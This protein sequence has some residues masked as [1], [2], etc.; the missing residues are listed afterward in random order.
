MIRRLRL[1]FI[2]IA[3]GSLLALFAVVLI[4]L[5]LYMFITSLQQ[6]GRTLQAVAA[7]DGIQRDG[8]GHGGDQSEALSE[9]D[10]MLIRHE[11]YFYLK[12]N[13]DGTIREVRMDK[14]TNY[15]EKDAKEHLEQVLDVG[16]TSGRLEGLQ[17]LAVEKEYG[18]LFVFVERGSDL[19]MLYRLLRVS[20]LS[21]GIG[22]ALLLLIVFFLSRWAVRPV[23]TAFEKQQQFVSDASH[24][25]KTPLTILSSNI[26]M[27]REEQPEN[28]ELASVQRQASRMNKLIHDLLIL[29][30]TEELD[31]LTDWDK[32]DFSKAVV[33]TV[34]EFESLALEE[35][36][37][38]LV[39]IVD[40]I[41][42]EGDKAQLKQVATILIDNAVKHSPAGGEIRV[43]LEE[44]HGK[45]RLAV[46]NTGEGI[47]AAERER[48]FERFYRVD[49]SR[50]RDTGGYGLGLSIAKAIVE[51]HGGSIQVE[52][53]DHGWVEFV[54]LFPVSK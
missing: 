51:R 11:N 27:L 1:K 42:Y 40:D 16:K 7:A 3:M 9:A 18:Y 54:V 24:E 47:P 4:S 35:N 30:R 17:Y 45:I 15:T 33:N 19:A 52:G 10:R 28:A 20:L 44:T 23:E 5:N 39:S 50:S 48:V 2:A 21:G 29:A 37:S 6:A 36:K 14:T 53:E 38:L 8:D 22:C 13:R 46:R 26:D 34:L 49:S 32:F 25:L 31:I 12:L 43:T 41:Q